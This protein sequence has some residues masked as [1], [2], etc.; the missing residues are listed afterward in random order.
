MP[1]KMVSCT[2]ERPLCEAA[3]HYISVQVVNC[4]KETLIAMR[5]VY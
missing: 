4:R 1:V 5:N 3:G 2:F